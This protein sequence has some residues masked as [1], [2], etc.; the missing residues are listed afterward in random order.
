MPKSIAKSKTRKS[1]ARRFKIT[2]SGKVMRMRSGARHLLLTKSA[3]R[4][5]RLGSTTEVSD[6]VVARIKESLPFH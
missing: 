2:G 4:K 5:R 6:T 3:K 1:V